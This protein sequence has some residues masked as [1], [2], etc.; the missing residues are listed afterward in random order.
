VRT[1]FLSFFKLSVDF[2][3]NWKLQIVPS[4]WNEKIQ[5]KIFKT[6]VVLFY[7]LYVCISPLFHL[8][9]G[10]DRGRSAAAERNQPHFTPN[11]RNQIFKQ[12]VNQRPS[13]ANAAGAPGWMCRIHFLYY[14]CQKHVI[15]LSVF[16]VLCMKRMKCTRINCRSQRPCVKGTYCPLQLPLWSWMY[17]CMFL[18]LFSLSIETLQQ[19]DPPRKSL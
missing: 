12:R 13:V 4:E 16:G 19:A 10:R 9:C 3:S 5:H 2:I 17:V 15:K 11:L 1:L 6:D 18:C 7:Q 14:H 8:E